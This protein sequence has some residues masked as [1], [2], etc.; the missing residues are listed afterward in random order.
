MSHHS[1]ESDLALNAKL[2]RMLE[3]VDRPLGAT[4]EHP[5]GRLTP[6]DE[7]GIKIAVGSKNGAVVINFGTPVAWI[8]FSPT[9]ARQLAESLVKHADSFDGGDPNIFDTAAKARKTA[10][11][12]HAVVL[13]C[14]GTLRVA[15]DLLSPDERSGAI[16]EVVAM[17]ETPAPRAQGDE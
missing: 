4:G 3:D 17:L 6:T 8:G 12:R 13:A 5:R 2:Q 7:G 14:Y 16:R 11:S 9:E 10:V 1:S 15:I